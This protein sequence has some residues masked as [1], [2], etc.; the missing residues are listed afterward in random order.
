MCPRAIGSPRD[1]TARW[2]N[3]SRPS[4]RN[5][6]LAITRWTT[7][8]GVLDTFYGFF[9]PGPE[10]RKV[11]G[12]IPDRVVDAL[13]VAGAMYLRPNTYGAGTGITYSPER[14]KLVWDEL[15]L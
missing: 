8:T 3:C 15:V 1:S 12:G 2:R 13:D 14:L 9:T 7:S 11:V 5:V 10:P 4:S 6:N